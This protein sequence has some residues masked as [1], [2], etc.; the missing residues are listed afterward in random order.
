MPKRSDLISM[1]WVSPTGPLPLL[2]VT[3]MVCLLATLQE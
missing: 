3:V 1:V 2:T